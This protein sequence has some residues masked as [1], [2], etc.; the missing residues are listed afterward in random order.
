M[1][2]SYTKEKQVTYVHG[3]VA[4]YKDDFKPVFLTFALAVFSACHNQ[5]LPLLC[6][7]LVGIGLFHLM[8]SPPLTDEQQ[9]TNLCKPLN[10]PDNSSV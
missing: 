2:K 9:V 5:P 7:F 4:L 3:S 1:G 8:S 6:L 10:P